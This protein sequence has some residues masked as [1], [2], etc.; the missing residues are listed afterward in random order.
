MKAPSPSLR[1]AATLILLVFLLLLILTNTRIAA[2]GVR[3]ALDLCTQTLLPS[4]FPF[5]ILSEL[6]IA[7]R[8]TDKPGKWL[9]KP[10]AALFGL[11]EGGTSA[12][13]LGALGGFTVGASA[14][15]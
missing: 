3:Q 8:V 7:F 1:T 9:K 6:L 2:E 11:S 10:F 12:L 5:L 13:L 4:L 15:V 14:A